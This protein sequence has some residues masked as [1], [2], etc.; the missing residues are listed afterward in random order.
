MRREHPNNYGKDNSFGGDVFRLHDLAVGGMRPALL[1]LLSAVFLVLLIACA[2]L[3]TMLLARAAAREREMA[4]RVALGAGPLR[5][6]KQVLTESVLLSLIGGIAGVLLALWGVELL[7][8]IGAQTVPRLREVNV[9]LGVLGVT[10]AIAVGTGIIFGLVP[11]LASA[12]PELTEA[13]KEGGRSSTQGT[14]R[15]R[16]RNGLVIA[17]VA[18]ALVL[19]SGAG[20]LMKSFARLQNVNPGFNP[21]NAL[22]F[23]VSLPKIQYPNDPSIV[24]FNSE[25]QR[26][27]AALPGVQAAGFSTILPLAGTN[28]DSSFAIEGPTIERSYSEPR[29]RKPPGFSGLFSRARDTTD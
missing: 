27:L 26:R 11:G 7:K 4:I 3:T 15:N 14:G 12:R 16:L 25:A 6:L 9:D 22:T 2:N 19:L 20:L 18:L 8:V 29:R 13:L 21:R 5:L 24:R 23:E 1:I 10:L 28:S 17:E